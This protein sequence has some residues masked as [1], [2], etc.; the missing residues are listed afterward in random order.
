MAFIWLRPWRATINCKIILVHLKGTSVMPSMSHCEKE[1]DTTAV[2]K[3]PQRQHKIRNLFFFCT[4][5][6][7]SSQARALGGFPVYRILM[8]F[9]PPRFLTN[10]PI[11]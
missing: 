4:V 3:Q 7:R 5:L 6:C 2:G 9:S 1:M 10:M 8:I 11:A